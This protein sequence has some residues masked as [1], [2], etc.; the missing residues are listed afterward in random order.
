MKEV[1]YG[2]ILLQQ[3]S[4]GIMV[5]TGLLIYIL[6]AVN[7]SLIITLITLVLGAFVFLLFKPLIYKTRI[8][9]GK[10]A[11]LNK[12][13]AHF[14]NQSIIGIKSIKARQAGQQVVKK[15]TEFFDDLRNN[16]IK[17]ALYKS[18]TGVF[19][20]PIVLIFICLVFAFSYKSADFNFA[21]LAA[22]IY[23]IQRIFQYIQ[24][25]EISLQRINE[26]YPFLK[27][28][29]SYEA[30]VLTHQEAV[31]GS[32]P[33][34]FN[35]S[36]EFDGVGFDYNSDSRVLDKVSFGVDKNE[37]VGLIGPSGAG[38]TTVVDLILRLFEPLSGRILLDGVDISEI[39]IKDWRQKIGYV[40]QD[41]FLINGTVA[42]N[43]RFYN[44][45]ISD[46]EVVT[47]AKMANIYDFIQTCPDKFETIVGE[48]GV[49]FSAGQRQRIVIAR[50]LAQQPELLIMDE[51]TSALDNESEGKIQKVIENLKGKITVFV[52]AH[53]LSTVIATDQLLVLKEGKIME[54]ASPEELLKNKESYFYKLYNL[55]K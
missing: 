43:I 40:S 1:E 41:M 16:K 10:I 35:R 29:L 47:A 49:L 17:A 31:T 46:E 42:E 7:I 38:K 24:Q 8:V 6:V 34:N 19:L 30:E 26:S 11:D 39:D 51:A 44:D 37:M 12:V 48:R 52:I 4:S 54:Q 36:L 23:L 15:A 53:R 32:K 45:A 21:V 55:R 50:I 2:S 3:I 13:I 18:V 5:I 27:S 22:I 33:F 25:L 20:Q 14:V 28:S 9:S